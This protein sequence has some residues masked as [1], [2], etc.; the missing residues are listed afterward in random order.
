MFVLSNILVM[1]SLFVNSYNARID[2]YLY[3]TSDDYHKLTYTYDTKVDVIVTEKDIDI[4]FDNNECKCEVVSYY[5]DNLGKYYSCS[6][7]STVC[8]Y[9]EDIVYSTNYNGRF[10]NNIIVI[11]RQDD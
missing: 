11:S 9:D 4:N 10:N 3:D 1:L 6:D 8:F 5:Q 7:N 2:V